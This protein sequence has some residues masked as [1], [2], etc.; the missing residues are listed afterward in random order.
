MIEQ[1]M[2]LIPTPHS[3][4]LHFYTSRLVNHL[5][6]ESNVSHRHCACTWAVYAP[7]TVLAIARVT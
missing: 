1:L 5:G 2:S 6:D 7:A 4:P 3:Q